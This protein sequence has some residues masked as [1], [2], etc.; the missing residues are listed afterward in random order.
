MAATSSWIRVDV[1]APLFD[2]R[3]PDAPE[4][5]WRFLREHTTCSL[6][7]SEPLMLCVQAAVGFVDLRDLLRRGKWTCRRS[8][9]VPAAFLRSATTSSSPPQR[10]A[11]PTIFIR[12]L[13][14]L[15]HANAS[16]LP[17][18]TLERIDYWDDWS[19]DDASSD[20]SSDTASSDA[21]SEVPPGGDSSGDWS[22]GWWEPLSPRL[23]EPQAPSPPRRPLLPSQRPISLCAH[24]ASPAPCAVCF[25][26]VST[27]EPVPRLR[28]KHVF[29]GTC[30]NQ[31]RACGGSTC[32][33]CRHAL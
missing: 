21:S 25:R 6:H 22:S 32:P 7:P 13:L 5:L 26:D 28:C 17:L 16:L 10:S 4:S 24:A 12:N 19:S 11:V 9:E 15:I 33:L 1:A 29:H 20:A 18:R 23:A 14:S 27:G 3:S 8:A 31:W 30:L 2:A